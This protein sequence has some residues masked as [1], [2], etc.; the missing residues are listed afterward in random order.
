MKSFKKTGFTLIELL[1]VVLI[2]AILAAIAVP[3]FLEFQTRAK[4]SRV[5][6]DMR[7]LETALEAYAVDNNEYPILRLYYEGGISQFNRGGIYNVVDLTTPISYI[8]N[9]NIS[10]PFQPPTPA[11]EFGDIQSESM[12][13]VS[14]GINYINIEQCR[15]SFGA[16]AVNTKYVLLSYGPDKFRGPIP[17]DSN[18]GLFTYCASNSS[19]AERNYFL[20]SQYDP[21]NGTVSGGDII[22]FQGVARD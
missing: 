8:T 15:V 11:D 2:I 6:S 21:T 4:V 10:D 18:P 1:I 7:S 13:P 3:N 16:S 14:K 12:G 20:T 5:K 19:P 22:R 17:T 9:V